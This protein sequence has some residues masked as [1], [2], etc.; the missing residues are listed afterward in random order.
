M[1]LPELNKD[2]NATTLW[3]GGAGMNTKDYDPPGLS[4]PVNILPINLCALITGLPK[5]CRAAAHLSAR[6]PSGGLFLK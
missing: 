6:L 2:E 4:F 1:T 5:K 3:E